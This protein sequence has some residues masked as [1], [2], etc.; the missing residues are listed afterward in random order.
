MLKLKV[1]C[2]S[3]ESQATCELGADQ[4]PTFTSCSCL[5]SNSRISWL[6]MMATCWGWLRHLSQMPCWV[7]SSHTGQCKVVKYCEIVPFRPSSSLRAE[8]AALW[9]YKIVI[10]KWVWASFITELLFLHNYDFAQALFHSLIHLF[11]MLRSY[12]MPGTLPNTE[13]PEHPLPLSLRQQQKTEVIWI[14]ISRENGDSKTCDAL[15]FTESHIAP[16]IF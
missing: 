16:S 15:L 11:N 4:D 3:L 13:I 12:Y 5:R 1:I 9:I 6:R 14:L 8:L 10:Q 2:E 7:R